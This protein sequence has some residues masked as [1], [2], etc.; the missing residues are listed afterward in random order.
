MRFAF[1]PEDRKRL[2]MP[3]VIIQPLTDTSDGPV[4]PALS[5]MSSTIAAKTASEGSSFTVASQSASNVVLRGR[6]SLTIEFSTD[7]NSI[8][9]IGTKNVIIMNRNS[10]QTNRR[11]LILSTQRP[12]QTDPQRGSVGRNKDFAFLLCCVCHE[13]SAK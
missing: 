1:R 2:D 13:N 5:F 9:T 3:G 11:A 4:F 12:R 8:S 7:R 10:G 6:I